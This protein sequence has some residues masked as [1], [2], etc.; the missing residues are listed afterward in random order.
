MAWL[1][2]CGEEDPALSSELSAL[3]EA[4]SKKHNFSQKSLDYITK[5][6][7]RISLVSEGTASQTQIDDVLVEKLRLLCK[8][9]DV[10]PTAGSISSH[11][12]FIGPIIVA[13]KKALFSMLRVLLKPAFEKQRNFN[14]QVIEMLAE[15]TKRSP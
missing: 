12:K 14:A 9:W 3:A 5:L 10:Y 1:R 11:R 13:F 4:A 6:D 15:F 7:R 8:F 2:I